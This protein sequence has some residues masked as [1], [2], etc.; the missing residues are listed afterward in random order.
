[1][2]D[3]EKVGML[4]MDFLACASLTVI[5]NTIKNIRKRAWMMR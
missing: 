4:K 2:G 5:E 1:M 3:L